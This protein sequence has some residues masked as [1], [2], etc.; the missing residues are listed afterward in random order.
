[1]KKEQ[2][3]LDH[4]PSPPPSPQLFDS[5]YALPDSLDAPDSLLLQ[6]PSLNVSG[7]KTSK[8]ST[9]PN[10]SPS[11]SPHPPRHLCEG[12]DALFDAPDAPDSLPLQ[13]PSLKISGPKISKT[14]IAPD[15]SPSPKLFENVKIPSIS[16]RYIAPVPSPMPQSCKVDNPP[17]IA[18][19][20]SP[21]PHPNVDLDSLSNMSTS[22]M[23]FSSKETSDLDYLPLSSIRSPPRH[24]IGNSTLLS[25]VPDLDPT[26]NDRVSATEQGVI[27]VKLPAFSSPHLMNRGECLPRLQ[28]LIGTNKS[29]FINAQVQVLFNLSCLWTSIYNLKLKETVEFSEKKC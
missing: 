11:P 17:Y 24:P 19:I 25:D 20:C 15:S 26:N 22:A 9:A 10:P 14:S 8:T 2:E 3:A 16:S 23:H 7:L 13:P 5:L 28:N 6:R 1:M 29:C 12:S 21:P 18:P 27:P 4:D